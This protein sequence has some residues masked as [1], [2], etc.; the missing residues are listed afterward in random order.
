MDYFVDCFDE[1]ICFNNIKYERVG[2]RLDQIVFFTGEEY[3]NS[4]DEWKYKYDYV[5][6]GGVRHLYFREYPNKKLLENLVNN[7]YY[8]IKNS[9]S[10]VDRIELDTFMDSIFPLYVDEEDYK[11]KNIKKL[12]R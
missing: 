10:S 7:L 9:S 6:D 4:F 2:N 11:S 3:I 1:D 8:S 12:I 5:F